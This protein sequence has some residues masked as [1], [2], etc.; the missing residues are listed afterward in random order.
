MNE[1]FRKPIVKI[2]MLKG[3]EGQSIKEIKK[4]STSGL[5]D[6]YT[7]TLTDGTTSTFTVANGAKGDKGEGLPKGGKIGQYLRKKS[8]VDYDY[9]WSDV[10]AVLWD[11]VTGKPDA[12]PTTWDDVTGKPDAYPTAWDKVSGKPSTFSPTPSV[13]KNFTLSASNWRA[14]NG[15]TIYVIKDSLITADSNQEVIPHHSISIE[16]YKAFQRA[17]LVGTQKQGELT[18]WVY[19]T[20]PTIDIPI[21][22]IFRGTI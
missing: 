11:N 13:T 9:E 19:G 22:I 6:T 5:V 7:I 15:W 17:E 3:Q 14:Q 12:Y 21:T 8:N 16:Q 1:F 10:I 20:K 2:L 4:T 18:L